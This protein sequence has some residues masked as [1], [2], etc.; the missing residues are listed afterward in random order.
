MKLTIDSQEFA[1]AM[2]FVARFSP[3]RPTSIILGGVMMRVEN[4]QLHLSVFD[5]Q[6]AASTA[7]AA[8]VEAD[9]SALVHAATLQQWASKLPRKPLTIE[10]EDSTLKLRCGPVRASLPL[11]PIDDYP[12]VDLVSQPVVTIPGAIFDDLVQRTAF[13][14]ATDADPALLTAVNLVA[15]N[16]S[17]TMSATDRY[18]VAHMPVK[19]ATSGSFEASIPALALRE[20][21]KAFAT[22]DEVEIG[23][24]GND[25]LTFKGDRGMIFS[26][27]LVGK[28]PPVDRL[29][30]SEVEKHAVLSAEVV[31]EA[32]L[33]A[34]LALQ[35]RGAVRFSFSED[36]CTVE[37]TSE[38]K[39]MVEEFEVAFDGGELDINL[40]PQFLVD[41]LGACRSEDVHMW[42]MPGG[43]AGKPGPVMLFGGDGFRY[44]LQPN[45]LLREG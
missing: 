21:A 27:P 33:R 12:N 36:S 42:F 31:S 39:G 2:S 13:A 3:K 17:L 44:L 11:M 15:G 20:T 6:N 45:L 19:C 38:G 37:G 29:F 25:S 24:T 22:S 1:D 10:A 26:R 18:R 14:A 30:P 4:G 7:L 34:A 43:S 28:F 23:L 35:P 9:G 41:G 5:F 8:E 40:R 32:T 16:D